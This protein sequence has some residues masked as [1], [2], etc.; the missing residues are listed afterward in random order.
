MAYKVAKTKE[1]CL[2]QLKD[3]IGAFNKEY[4]IYKT[5]KYSE[6]QLRID[7]LNP[8]LKTFGWDV[9]NENRKSQF[10]CDVLQEE[11]IDV[12]EEDTFDKYYLFIQRAINLLNE[13]GA[14][15]YIVPHKFFIV[16]G[17]K[18]L[19]SFILSQSSVH[20]II[21]FGVSQ[22]F[23]NRSTYTAILIL[24]KNESENIFFKRIR[25]IS[26]ELNAEISDYEIYNQKSLTE[27]PWVFVSK[28][29]Q[30]VF[31][32]IRACKNKSLNAIAE[33]AV[34]LQTSADKVYIFQPTSES[35]KTYKFSFRNQ[36][37]EIEK[38]ICK[39][40]IY[41]LSFG[42]FDTVKPNAQI[43]FPYTIQTDKAEVFS[44]EYF[45][46]N[47]PLSWAYLNNFKA[48]LSRRSINGS[49]EPKWY[50]YG[51]SQSLTRFYNTHKLI[52]PVLST[53]P[54]YV[55]DET[56]LQFT[57][58]GNGPYYSLFVRPGNK[59]SIF[60]ILGILAHPIFETMVKSGASEFRGAYY[61]HGKQFIE[62]LPIKQIDFAKKK[63]IS[64]HN[65]IVKTVKQ[66]IAAKESVRGVYHAAKKSVL[67]RKTDLL[68]NALFGQINLLYGV[69]DDEMKI[70]L[71]DE[72]LNEQINQE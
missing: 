49:K 72:M 2:V 63:E 57:G 17:G 51:R 58:G 27:Q 6:A 7:F 48:E 24:G 29:T 28:E 37:Y 59:Y 3:L 60:Y 38:S 45:Q 18:E 35:D 10:F 46:K 25:K 14:L 34:G 55:F 44:E 70:V 71:N 65:E 41:D 1:E 15:G 33:I 26:T 30:L 67:Q 42:L 54:S 61:S 69:T 13:S 32:K 23:P 20:K 21:H 16:K 43:I 64:Q 68:L 40:C 22:V 66:L 47:Y 53:H 62:N 5:H 11:S 36:E 50:Q 12:K 8:L 4:A 52:W 31:D 39:S 56:N 19:R 9:D